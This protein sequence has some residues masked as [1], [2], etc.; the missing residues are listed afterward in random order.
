MENSVKRIIL[1]ENENSP[2]K[3]D[4]KSNNN[5][6]LETIRKKLDLKKDEINEENKIDEKLSFDDFFKLF[7]EKAKNFYQIPS[8][9]EQGKIIAEKNLINTYL[10]DELID[11]N[12]FDLF[13]EKTDYTNTL[14]FR[15]NGI[16]KN[17]VK[18]YADFALDI[19][20]CNCTKINLYKDNYEE[21]LISKI[22]NIL[23]LISFVFFLFSIFYF[24]KFKK[25][26]LKRMIKTKSFDAL[27]F[28]TKEYLCLSFNI[29]DLMNPNYAFNIACPD[30][31][32]FYYIS[33]FGISS[34]NEENENTANC[35]S[36][37]FKNLIKIDR[38]CD[39]GN[40]LDNLLSDF[41]YK[42]RTFEVVNNNLNFLDSLELCSRNNNKEK[43]FLSY[44]CYYP[45][46]TDK[47]ITRKEFI[48][49]VI[50]CLSICIILCF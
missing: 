28:Y 35:Y 47:N 43:V 5:N 7:L 4:K 48:R 1:Y 33:K 34:I 40:N 22:K 41:K 16:R 20:Y 9:K 23:L 42:T 38:D 15:K 39:Y 49:P 19:T 26:S 31:T 25:I 11:E 27:T 30:E 46:L 13:S 32:L 45:Y 37:S 24:V 29:S 8:N 12:Y 17:E 21:K 44:S 50:Q 2:C 36:K 10:K 3:T 18:S 6:E 14:M